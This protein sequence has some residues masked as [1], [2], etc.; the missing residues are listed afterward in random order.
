VCSPSG[1]RRD[2]RADVLVRVLPGLWAGT[3]RASAS[4][5]RS[6]AWAALRTN[7]GL[8]R[9]AVDRVS[10]DEDGEA[11][12]AERDR[13]HPAA[14]AVD[15]EDEVAEAVEPDRS[16]RREL[17]E[18]VP[19]GGDQGATGRAGADRGTGSEGAADG[20]DCNPSA[21]LEM[22]ANAGSSEDKALEPSLDPVDP[23]RF[24][25]DGD[26]IPLSGRRAVLRRST[27]A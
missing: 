11:P 13:P 15:A 24:A 21:E 27:A 17:A 4:L 1:R 10:G 20:G 16:R 25:E 8:V 14:G 6:R 9:R 7:C 3:S 26:V 5:R 22:D 18:A 19:V 23:E 2:I 12:F